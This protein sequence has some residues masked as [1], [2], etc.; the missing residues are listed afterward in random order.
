MSLQDIQNSIRNVPDFPK[1]GIQFKDITTAV[2]QPKILKEILETIAAQFKSQ[3]IDYVVGIESRGFIF[4]TALA[5]LLGCGFVPVRKPGKLPADVISQEYAL[6][7]GTDKIEMHK[8]ALHT[9]DRVLV[10]DDLLATGGTAAAAA[11][12]INQTGAEIIAFAFVIELADLGGR[13]LLE[14]YAKVCS[15]VKY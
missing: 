1:P 10:V 8:D 6:E 2:K 3:K 4:G 13:Q 14:D 11:K 15:L 9:G 7:Y 12:L 5:Y